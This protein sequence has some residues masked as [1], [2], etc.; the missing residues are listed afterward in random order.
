MTFPQYG[1][2]CQMGDGVLKVS[3]VGALRV[4]QHRPLEGTPKTC[5]IQRSSTGKWYVTIACEREVRPLPATGEAVGIDVGL[6]SFATLSTGEQL[7]DMY[8]RSPPALG[9]MTHGARIR[10]RHLEPAR[11]LALGVRED[12]AVLQREQAR[13]IV[14]VVVNVKDK[15]LSIRSADAKLEITK[16][17]ISQI[18][19]RK[20]ETVEA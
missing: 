5:T 17:A 20:G 3:K 9:G 12:L 2:G 18:T 16:A 1:N 6:L 14:G 15:T 19:S 7:G 8:A 4:V 13:E 10:R 11:D